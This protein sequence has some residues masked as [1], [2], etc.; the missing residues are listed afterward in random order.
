MSFAHYLQDAAG[1]PI[2]SLADDPQHWVSASR[3]R[4]WAIGDPLLDWLHVHGRGQG[5]VPDTDIPGYD[6]KLDF[7][8][9]LFEKGHAF[10]AAVI[11]LLDREITMV[12]LGRGSESLENARATFEAMAAGAEA[13]YQGVLWDAE[14][15][16]YGSADLLVRAD[17]LRRLFPEALDAEAAA[18][19]APGFAHDHHYRV[20]DIKYAT[21]HLDRHGEAGSGH[22]PFM[23]QTFVYNRA[24]GRI[25]GY[26]P[27]EAFLLGRGWEQGKE[28]GGAERRSWDCLDRLAP[29]SFTWKEGELCRL[30][31]GAAAWLREVR[32]E[33]GNWAVLP[34]PSRPELRP[35]MTTGMQA[36]WSA[37]CAA[38]AAAQGE[39]TLAWWAG[40]NAR[41][42]AHAG[43]IF[44]WDDPRCSAAS[45]GIA[46]TCLP[47]MVDAVLAVNRDTG[48]PAIRP[49]RISAHAER[50]AAPG[51]IEFF[52]DFETVTSL[53]DDF[54]R[55]PEQNGQNLIFM[56][57]CGHLEAGEW[58]F[59]CFIADALT[60]DAEARMLDEWYAHM[61]AVRA[62]LAPGL[63]EPLVFHWSPA[64]AS[65]L[66]NALSSANN[67]QAARGRHWP[68][69]NWFDFLKDVMK[70][71][72]AP[73]VVRGAMGFGLKKVANALHTHGAVETLWPDG[74]ADGL[75]AMVAAWR[76]AAEAKERGVP[77]SAIPLMHQVR[78]YNEV[79][80]RVMMETIRFLR[81]RAVRPPTLSIVA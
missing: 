20:L 58:R 59:A 57:G 48:G 24:L 27:P 62:R 23:V 14:H 54:A 65:A 21:L 72:T 53:D 36:P 63:A 31:D 16:M 2:P 60:E 79:D 11:S 18:V 69:P 61:E 77:L 32:G 28:R 47:G 45:L 15:R 75:G 52:V 19:R 37:A 41:E 39:I 56:V 12:K 71:K 29:V 74:V 66:T 44:R 42:I 64:E 13:V 35:N 68:A 78:D 5:F 1:R 40:V 7:R 9:F 43:G 25:Q 80:C 73:V 55:M 26:E 33:G 70:D 76:S 38:I 51:A 34:E 4:N 22:L 50:W 67:R 49:A 17:V 8:E 46:G 10:E 81:G 30:A 3:T 6:P